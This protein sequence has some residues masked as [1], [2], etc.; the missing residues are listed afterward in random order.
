[1]RYWRLSMTNEG[2]QVSADVIRDYVN[3][4]IFADATD[5]EGEVKGSLEDDYP[6][7]SGEREEIVSHRLAAEILKTGM[8]GVVIRP[9]T[10]KLPN[11]TLNTNWCE[12]T[13]SVYVD[14][15]DTTLSELEFDEDDG[16]IQ[17]VDTLVLDTDKADRAGYDIFRLHHRSTS[18]IVSDRLKQIMEGINPVGIRFNPTDGS[19]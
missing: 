17:F 1:M 11:G 14:C 9:I 7:F 13:V 15:I 10:L 16:R 4:T 18:V 19:E 6:F 12:L 5:G 2:V 8:E 3:Q